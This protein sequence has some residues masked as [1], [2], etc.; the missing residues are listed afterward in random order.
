[1]IGNNEAAIIRFEKLV[2]KLYNY[3]HLNLVGA[4]VTE[5]Q[6]V[7]SAIVL[8]KERFSD[9]DFKSTET[10]AFSCTFLNGNRY[11]K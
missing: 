2:R 3:Q 6:Q 7:N 9:A 11:Y 10:D 8:Q 1:M 5:G 4:D